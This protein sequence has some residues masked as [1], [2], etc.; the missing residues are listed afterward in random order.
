MLEHVSGIACQVANERLDG[1]L[2]RGLDDRRV[3]RSDLDPAEKPAVFDVE[4]KRVSD[5]PSRREV[6][7]EELRGFVRARSDRK[8]VAQPEQSFDTGFDDVRGG[9]APGGALPA[10]AS[11]RWLTLPAV[12]SFQLP[13]RL[14]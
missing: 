8:H 2:P 1:N 10:V 7:A 4:Q 3:S 9:T 5:I 14:Y 6:R 12:A 13:I 11:S